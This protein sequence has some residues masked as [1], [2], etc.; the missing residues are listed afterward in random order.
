MPPPSWTGRATFFYVRLSYGSGPTQINFV[1]PCHIPAVPTQL[2]VRAENVSMG[3]FREVL[4]IRDEVR[5]TL[6]FPM[7]F[8]SEV[9]ALR[10]YWDA[11]GKYGHQAALTLDRNSAATGQDEYD[12][13]NTY[14]TRAELLSN[15][16]A[17]QRRV[18]SDIV[19]A[20]ELVFRQGG[21]EV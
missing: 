1:N 18:I 17:P 12:A 20:I 4:H 11:W 16:F 6:Q 7:L 8:K 21:D 14:F 10:T 2:A 9:V 19:Y 15:P 13:W 5:I 3:G